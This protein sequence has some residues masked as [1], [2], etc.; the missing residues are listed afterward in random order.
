MIVRMLVVAAMAVMHEQMH[1]RTGQQEQIGQY[2]QHMRA[3]FGKQKETSNC[4]E[5]IKHPL[6]AGVLSVVIVWRMFV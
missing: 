6:A 2:S 1:Q 4:E 3:V 5:A